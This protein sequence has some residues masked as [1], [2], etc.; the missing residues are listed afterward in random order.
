MVMHGG[1]EGM[2][3]SRSKKLQCGCTCPGLTNSDLLYALS[4]C[5]MLMSFCSNASPWLLLDMDQLASSPHLIHAALLAFL[6]VVKRRLQ[7][8]LQNHLLHVAQDDE[9]TRHGVSSRSESTSAAAARLLLC[10][11]AQVVTNAGMANGNGAA[12]LSSP[13]SVG[14]VLMAT[15]HGKQ[16]QRRRQLPLLLPP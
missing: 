1:C 6:P 11:D 4:F 3:P 9:E 10:L 13:A 7:I 5:E 12:A 14:N 8:A 15:L 2:P 16:Q